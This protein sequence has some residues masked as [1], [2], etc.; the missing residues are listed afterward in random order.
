T[1]DDE[2]WEYEAVDP[3][4]GDAYLVFKRTIDNFHFLDQDTFDLSLV[5]ES[6]RG[7]DY[8]DKQL[9][10]KPGSFSGYPSLDVKEKMKDGAE[11]RARYIIRGADYYVIAARSK[12]KKNGLNDFFD[13]FH[14]ADY[15]YGSPM[16]YADT[17]MHFTVSTPVV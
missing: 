17:F 8:F 14:F 1:E 12:N 4:T 2:R 6:F 7:P 15:S 16:A 11:V 10:R 5:E 9:S 13:S 3:S